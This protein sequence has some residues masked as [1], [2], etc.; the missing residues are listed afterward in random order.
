MPDLA[1]ALPEAPLKALAKLQGG[2]R[3]FAALHRAD[4][5]RSYKRLPDDTP[6]LLIAEAEVYYAFLKAA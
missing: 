2:H 4:L 3:R 6:Q 1:A 5:N